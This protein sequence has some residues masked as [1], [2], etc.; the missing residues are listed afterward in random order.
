[1]FLCCDASAW[2]YC[3]QPQDKSAAKRRQLNRRTEEQAVDRII[4]T[5]F[6]GL[7]IVHRETHTV[8]GELLRDRLARDKRELPPGG[9]LGACYYRD[10][11]MEWS[12]GQAGWA[13]LR[14][15]KQGEVISDQLVHALDLCNHSN[16]NTRTIEPLTAF[17][18]NTKT[19]N[20]TEVYGAVKAIAANSLVGQ[21]KKDTV[22][23][24]IMEYLVKHNQDKVWPELMKALTKYTK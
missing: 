24:E 14:P 4:E 21:Q 23:Q 6:G 20:Q 15:S 10:L 3:I 22:V 13:D 2:V 16:P 11:L 12:S 7:D 18:R 1:M 9:R 8:N 5:K 17:L 19:L